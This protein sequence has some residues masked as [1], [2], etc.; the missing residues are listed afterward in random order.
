MVQKLNDDEEK[1]AILIDVMT[2]L[3]EN[4]MDLSEENIL[5]YLEK[6]NFRAI[7]KELKSI[8]KIRKNT[9][10]CIINFYS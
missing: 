9:N 10:S 5:Y 7:K 1:K 2:Y 8:K 3:A 4:N 6:Q